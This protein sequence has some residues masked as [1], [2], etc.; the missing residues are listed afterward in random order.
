MDTFDG[1]PKLR[2]LYLKRNKIAALT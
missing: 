1:N 2:Q